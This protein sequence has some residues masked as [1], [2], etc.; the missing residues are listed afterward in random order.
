[1][2]EEEDFQRA[3]DTNPEDWWM[4]QLFAEWL[5]DH[6]DPRA[7]GYLAIARQKRRPLQGKNRDR[8]V[9]WWHCGS[10]DFHNNLARDWFALLPE[11][12]RSDLFWPVFTADARA[13]RTRRECED[14]LALAFRELPAERRAELLKAPA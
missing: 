8:D 11:D 12:G 14:A 10:S 7:E 9:W 5:D 13:V 1:M 4:R 3:L 2:T 6:G